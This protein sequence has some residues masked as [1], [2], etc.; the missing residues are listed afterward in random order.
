LNGSSKILDPG[1]KL[2]Q[3]GIGKGNRLALPLLAMNKSKDSDRKMV[4]VQNINA[5]GFEHRLDAAKYA[6]MKEALLKVLPKK[7][8]GLTQKQMRQ[9]V[10]PH[11]PEDEFP[12]GAKAEWWSKCVQLDLEAKGIV[13]RD[14]KAKPLQW[15]R[16][17]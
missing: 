3:C 4:L 6:A 8:P 14:G 1:G 7:L 17:K 13:K 2:F 12:G 5:P 10:L 9:A 11:L 16:I 15:F